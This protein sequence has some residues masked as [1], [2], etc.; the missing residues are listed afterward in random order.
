MELSKCRQQYRNYLGTATAQS[1][2]CRRKTSRFT[3][4]IG[5]C[6]RWPTFRWTN[7]SPRLSRLH[8]VQC[9]AGVSPAPLGRQSEW[10]NSNIL[11]HHFLVTPAAIARSNE[12]SRSAGQ[13]RR[14]PYFPLPTYGLADPI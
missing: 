4:G 13:A 2:L 1:T 5:S 10:A 12:T 7:S 9:R 6:C 11:A 3:G 14:P 8:A